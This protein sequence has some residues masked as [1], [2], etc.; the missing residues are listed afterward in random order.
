MEGAAAVVGGM[1][2]RGI[3]KAARNERTEQR[4]GRTKGSA[5]RG[6][7][8]REERCGEGMHGA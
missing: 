6:T 4:P 1:G 2:A 7:V 3:Y 8:G 5:Q